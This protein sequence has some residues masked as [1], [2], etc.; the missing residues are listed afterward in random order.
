MIVIDKNRILLLCVFLPLS[1]LLCGCLTN[2]DS[3]ADK[4]PVEYVICKDSNCPG[5]LQDLLEEKKKTAG[6]FIYKNSM[7]MYLVVCYG[8]K[9]YSGYSIRVEECSR[10]EDTLYLRT[11]LLG[12]ELGE[13]VVETET[14]PCI[15]IR[16]EKMD[17]LC[18]MDS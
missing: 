5:Q 13:K 11:Q 16:C 9:P 10:S 3:E 12:P 1:I 6:T 17:V 4:E 7:Y 15:V 14:F 2:L 18:K 8:S